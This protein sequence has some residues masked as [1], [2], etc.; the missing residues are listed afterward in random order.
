MA[1]PAHAFGEEFMVLELN[2]PGAKAFE[3]TGDY[4]VVDI[5]GPLEQHA[6]WMCDSYDAI[7][8]RFNAALSSNAKAVVL[9]INSPG[10]DFAGS[11]ELSRELKASAAAAKKELICFTDSQA[12]S[13]GYI[14]ACA[15]S[16]IVVT[17]TAFVGSIG[18]W[19]PI[20]DET[21]RDKAMGLNVVIVASGTR[22]VDSNPHVAITEDAVSAMQVQVDT[23][24]SMFFELVHESRGMPLDSIVGLQG[25]QK[26][27]KGATSLHL[28]DTV[29]NSWGAFLANGDSG[30]MAKSYGDHMAAHRANLEKCAEGDDE[31][32]K[33]A[34][35]DLKAWDEKE[36]AAK[37]AEEEEMKKKDADG[38]KDASAKAEDS[39]EQAKAADFEKKDDK[40][41]ARSNLRVVASASDS[42]LA[43]VARVHALETERA[44][45]KEAAERVTL[46]SSRPDFS[47]EVK[48]SLSKYPIN[49]V[50]DA[51]KT[52]PKGSIPSAAVVTKAPTRGEAQGDSEVATDRNGM[53]KGFVGKSE[54]D[55]IDHAMSRGFGKSQGV[56]RNGREMVLGFMTPDEAR[57]AHKALTEKGNVK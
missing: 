30:T 53:P 25:A 52:F 34:Q 35:R 26:F 11:I 41:A 54:E 42:E 2:A 10:G 57:A 17:P 6:S 36:A 51:V 5:C 31:D 4:A 22:K 45:E 8:E 18:V 50:R 21:Q 32:A 20:V 12:L 16:R 40:A 39:D 28:A 46:L 19:A 14:L 1:M 38:D 3:E 23:M 7:R 33:A 27:G 55:F 15:A 24:A 44:L 9:R 43:L 13:A 37:A 56:E 48:A 47:A 49:V 29:V